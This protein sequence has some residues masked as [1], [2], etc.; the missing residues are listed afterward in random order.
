MSKE[1]LEKR[2]PQTS[3][4]GDFQPDL[5]VAEDL[6][7]VK[8]IQEHED[9]GINI[10]DILAGDAQA[11]GVSAEDFEKKLQNLAGGEDFFSDLLFTITYQRFDTIKAREIWRGIIKHKYFLSEK[12]GRNVGVRVAALDFL[13]NHLKLI[14]NVRLLSE[15]AMDRIT[16]F[17]NI[18]SLTGV[19]NHRFF[20][21]KLK[22]MVAQAG[23]DN[24]KLSILMLDVDNFKNYNDNFGHLFG[25]VIL[26]QVA[27]TIK[28][29]LRDQDVVSRYGGDEFAV[30]L[31]DSPKEMAI[32][33]ADRIRQ[34]IDHKRFLKEDHELHV[35]ITASIG[36]ATY[37]DDAG[38]AQ[39]LFDAAD[40]A[41]YRAKKKGKNQIA[42]ATKKKMKNDNSSE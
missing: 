30:L 39:E 36:V 4:Q 24:K 33:V 9:K 10:I 8:M 11:E 2:E 5:A 12:L 20:Q 37:P 42:S 1:F 26:R 40:K 34:E 29:N 31:P 13:S 22:E 28:N 16:V 14:Q 17:V 18:D 19:Y 38:T 27:F 21:D 6:D 25:D 7:I 3:G 23:R 35:V 32:V 41:M 15:D